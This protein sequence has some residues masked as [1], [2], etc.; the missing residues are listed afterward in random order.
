MV[1]FCYKLKSSLSGHL[2]TLSSHGGE[3]ERGE[4]VKGF[5]KGNKL[6]GISFYKGTNTIMRASPYNLN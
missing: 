4:K 5:G 3:R 6:S 1:G 2:L